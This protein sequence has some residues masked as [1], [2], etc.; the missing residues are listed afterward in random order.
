MSRQSSKIF[1][2]LR[3][4]WL[5]LSGTTLK[6]VAAAAVVSLIALIAIEYIPGTSF[7]EENTERVATEATSTV[8]QL[9]LLDKESATLRS[10]PVAIIDTTSSSGNVGRQLAE[11]PASHKGNESFQSEMNVFLQQIAEDVTPAE[12]SETT[13]LPL[14]AQAD[15]SAQSSV[16]MQLKDLVNQAM[17]PTATSEAAPADEEASDQAETT[18]EEIEA[19]KSTGDLLKELV[20]G[21]SA[22]PSV[23]GK[24]DYVSRLSAESENTGSY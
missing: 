10:Q 19:P 14:L 23:T 5:V 24:S 21:A 15:T 17:N 3:L 2:N 4:W 9:E 1:R 8:P 20:G 7:P 18:V 22:T 11:I 13:E 16:Q 6:F 12:K